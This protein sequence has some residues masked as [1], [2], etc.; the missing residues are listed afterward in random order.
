MPAQRTAA[1][2]S[3]LFRRASR[4]TLRFS[5]ASDIW[6]TDLENKRKLIIPFQGNSIYCR[7][8]IISFSFTYFV[9]YTSFI[10]LFMESFH[11]ILKLPAIQ[12]GL[13]ATEN[14]VVR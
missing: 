4:I 7:D 14:H 5:I 10:Q 1:I 6:N 3:N 11:L 8:F 9:F 13:S 12:D 2:T